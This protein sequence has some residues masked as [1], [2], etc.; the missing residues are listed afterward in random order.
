MPRFALC[1]LGSM[2]GFQGRTVTARRWHWH[3]A[4]P[5]SVP[6]VLPQRLGSAV[7]SPCS[8]TGLLGALARLCPIHPAWSRPSQ[9]IRPVLVRIQSL[10]TRGSAAPFRG[11]PVS[12]P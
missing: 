4:R 3:Q 7:A 11:S 10:P 12:L 5:S 6:S 8:G 1:V 2:G 9:P